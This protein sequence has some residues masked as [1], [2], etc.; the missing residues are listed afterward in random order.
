MNIFIVYDRFCRYCIEKILDTK[1]VTQPSNI[2]Q[3]L[4]R[5]DWIEDD[6]NNYYFMINYNIKCTV[7]FK[8]LEHP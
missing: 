5:H 1:Y 8:S 4:K 6:Q 2:L 3:K 7:F